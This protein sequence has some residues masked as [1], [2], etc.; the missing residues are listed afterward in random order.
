MQHIV[1][2]DVF[3]FSQHNTSEKYLQLPQNP[4]FCNSAILLTLYN[5]CPLKCCHYTISYVFPNPFMFS[6]L[7]LWNHYLGTLKASLQ[8]LI[9]IV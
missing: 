3:S 5:K 1:M 9:S 8:K 4:T 6:T 7:H 2:R